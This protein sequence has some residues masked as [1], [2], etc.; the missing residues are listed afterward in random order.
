M[1]Y[2]KDQ[3]LACFFKCDACFKY[4]KTA[5]LRLLMLA[6]TAAIF[7]YLL[8]ETAAALIS[9]VWIAISLGTIYRGIISEIINE[10]DNKLRLLMK[11]NGMHS[12]YY[13]IGYILIAFKKSLIV[14]SI[15]SLGFIPNMVSIWQPINVFGL[16]V[17]CALAM[18]TFALYFSSFFES[19]SSNMVINLLF[20]FLT[21]IFVFG[22]K[23]PNFEFQ[24][25]L[26][27]FPTSPLCYGL[28]MTVYDIKLL[29]RYDI[30]TC[31]ILLWTTFVVYYALYVI[32]MSK[33]SIKRF[34]KNLFEEKNL[35]IRNNQRRKKTQGDNLFMD[36]LKEPMIG[37]VEIVS[38]KAKPSI[39]LSRNTS[40]PR[41]RITT[42]I[43]LPRKPKHTIIQTMR[44]DKKRVLEVKNVIKTNNR[45]K[46][47]DEVSFRVYE[48]ETFCMVITNQ[49]TKSVLLNVLTGI[50]RPNCGKIKFNGVSIK[51][52]TIEPY[53][54]FGV[55]LENTPTIGYM[56]LKEHLELFCRLRSVEE[57]IIQDRVNY[58]LNLVE[59][60]NV[61][62]SI[63]ETLT[64]FQQRKMAIAIALTGNPELLILD[65]PTNGLDAM[66][67]RSM[68]ALIKLLKQ[69]KKTMLIF[70]HISAEAEELADRIGIM[71]D[72]KIVC[73]GTQDYLRQMYSVGYN[74]EIRLNDPNQDF[75][76]MRKTVAGEIETVLGKVIIVPE[77]DQVMH[78]F[79]P[80]HQQ[81]L[82]G[83]LFERLEQYAN[84]EFNLEAYSLENILTRLKCNMNIDRTRSRSDFESFRV[85][86]FEEP[87][88]FYAPPKINFWL[89]TK[90]IIRQ[91][92][93]TLKDMTEKKIWILFPIFFMFFK[94]LFVG[95]P[96]HEDRI[97]LDLFLNLTFG[98][99]TYAHSIVL[100]RKTK[101][102]LLLMVSGCRRMPYWFGN[103]IYDSFTA[104][105]IAFFFS[106]QGWF[107]NYDLMGEQPHY[108]FV[109]LSCFLIAMICLAY[110]WS[111][112]Y[113]DPD[114]AQRT[115]GVTLNIFVLPIP[116]IL[117]NSR[118]PELLPDW[119]DFR[120]FAYLL[121]PIQP[122]CDAVEAV[123]AQTR[124]KPDILNTLPFPS[125]WQY[126]GV[127]IF[128]AICYFILVFLYF[129]KSDAVLFDGRKV[130]KE[131][132]DELLI[133]LLDHIRQH[134]G[135]VNDEIHRVRDPGNTDLILV[136]SL[137]K[138]GSDEK[139]LIVNNLTFGVKRTEIFGLVG[140]ARSGKTTILELLAGLQPRSK[141]I[142]KLF[143]INIYEE[144]YDIF[145]FIGVST[146]GT[147]VWTSLT[148]EEQLRV[149]G[150]IKGLQEETLENHVQYVIRTLELSVVAKTPVRRLGIEYREKL[151][152]GMA[153]MGSPSIILLDEPSLGF[154]EGA[155]MKL[156]ELLRH[157]ARNQGAAIIYMTNNLQEALEISHR[158]GVI[159][160]GTFIW[161]GD[162][163]D[164]QSRYHGRYNILI[165][166]KSK[167]QE[168]LY[169][170]LSKII[171]DL[172]VRQDGRQF[173][174]FFYVQSLSVSFSRM[175]KELEEL[176]KQGLVRDFAI[177]AASF[178]QAYIYVSR[179]Q[180]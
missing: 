151:S 160:N 103:L 41:P 136:D 159:V 12:G 126:P 177:T 51:K 85:Y 101:I 142:I 91:K 5:F 88:Q 168:S 71:D 58:L 57:H 127:I 112:M 95:F 174:E 97:K 40:S 113:S 44:I 4:D 120:Y 33:S 162:K 141:G 56:T 18:S 178:E 53:K 77:E 25:F 138:V 86:K 149:F 148:I 106:F 37:L 143:G 92:H 118:I 63:P 23:S 164:I 81:D 124:N 169:P 3:I 107:F 43:F 17:S 36:S 38:E 128:Q 61:K 48:G 153:L 55:C 11:M 28:G 64:T 121:G 24:L 49:E 1:F 135:Q 30:F 50:E 67:R 117:Q 9:Q 8:V 123:Y 150:M 110:C 29:T 111:G 35:V 161:V 54:T 69:A 70:T 74:L 139:S 146:Q 22:T 157:Y 158:V 62:D 47:L 166:K 19:T 72:T 155:K 145:K 87:Q 96:T 82:L 39:A 60:D 27:L 115:L 122:L 163:N 109:L 65:E 140:P 102:K 154:S 89:Q 75:N 16:Y 132:S 52:Q 144:S 99:G 10:K 90:A 171:P 73:K 31:Y 79:I 137:Y 179:F 175:F 147:A 14:A 66:S 130:K 59:L 156:F 170:T 26:S 13:Y 2:P 104:V 15:I 105:V 83:K 125:R 129:D 131:H 176:K 94:G 152:L 84:L 80:K 93:A 6:I 68:W 165:E 98:I 20:Q 21:L 167:E 172:Q 76:M 116:F 133:K 108:F 134:D 46:E 114:I 173:I 119:L 45:N 7:A 42:E 34:V 78:F 180:A 32:K 100:D